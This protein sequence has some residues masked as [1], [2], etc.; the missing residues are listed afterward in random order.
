MRVVGAVPMMT[1]ITDA[2]R[3]GFAS[4]R[5]LARGRFKRSPAKLEVCETLSLGSRGFLAVVRCEG[6]RFLVGGT[7]TSL[8]LLA[9]LPGTGAGRESEFERSDRA[10]DEE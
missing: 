6:Q 5:L 3:S 9:T 2:M 8:G 1:A 7:S 4:L 10:A